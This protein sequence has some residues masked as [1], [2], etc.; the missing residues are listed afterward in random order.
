MQT[1]L[2]K[3]SKK[4]SRFLLASA[5]QALQN[6]KLTED[7]LTANQNAIVLWGKLDR[8]HKITN[9]AGVLDMYPSGKLVEM[10]KCGH[11][12][13]LEAPEDFAKAI[14]TVAS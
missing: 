13:D 6:E 5:L 7:D 10:E 8:T 14:Y 4:G 2:C 12:P 3:L 9:R 11:F 1:K